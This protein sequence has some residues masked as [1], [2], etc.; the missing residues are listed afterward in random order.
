M[1][2]TPE[3]SSRA[4][5]D[6]LLASALVVCGGVLFTT[7]DAVEHLTAAVLRFERVQLDDLMLTSS[8]AVAAATWFALRR[9]RESV[10]Q[11]RALQ[12]SEGEKARYVS[13][14][15]ELSAALL[16]AEERERERLSHVLHDEV[17]QTLYAC[18]L[19]LERAGE[20][21]VDAESRAMLEEA[22]LL[23]SAAMEQT[24][25]LTTELSP[26]ILSDLGLREAV[27][28]LLGRM[29]ARYGLRARCLP[30]GDWER[31]PQRF[32]SPVFHSVREL[33]VNAGKHAGAGMVEV[34]V[35]SHGP[36]EV[37]VRVADDGRGFDPG[38]AG[39]KGF[40]LFSIERR[41]ACMGAELRIES[42]HGRGTSAALW[43]HGTGA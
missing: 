35:A 4:G 16:D 25:E 10:R 30:G 41:M 9:W 3:W 13:K 36:A 5:R 8:L 22:R 18:R 31:I 17:G 26:P 19:Q 33:L 11:L 42:A 43:I 23:A 29:H 2:R 15:E 37:C 39:C 32:H 38:R 12:Q 27:E 34:S 28:W 7:L 20:R 40:G 1:T 24:R 6:A 14:L 21:A